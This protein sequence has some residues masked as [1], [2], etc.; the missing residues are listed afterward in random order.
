MIC[1]TPISRITRAKWTGSIT[2]AV[3]HL[4]LQA[5]SPQFNPQSHQKNKKQK[6]KN[7]KKSRGVLKQNRVPCLTLCN[8]EVWQWR[9]LKF[10]PKKMGEAENG[11]KG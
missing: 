11:R 7:Q 2:Q 4:L 6:P 1:E 3:V 5:P 9:E 10:T 8:S